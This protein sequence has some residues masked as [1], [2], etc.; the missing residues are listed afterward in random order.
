MGHI[1]KAIPGENNVTPIDCRGVMAAYLVLKEP[2]IN[3]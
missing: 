1:K 3:R 2:K